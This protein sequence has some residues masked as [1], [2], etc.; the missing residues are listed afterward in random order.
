MSI[1]LTFLSLFLSL[2]RFAYMYL[3]LLPAYSFN[4]KSSC[5]NSTICKLTPAI[6][7]LVENLQENEN[8]NLKCLQDTFK[9]LF[10]AHLNYHSIVN[11]SI[12]SPREVIFFTYFFPLDSF[13]VF[14]FLL[15]CWLRKIEYV[16]AVCNSVICVS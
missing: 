14:L 16:C 6:G 5:T 11:E 3:L 7:S 10:S 12:Y 2:Y 13:F 8:K 4:N 9:T 15:P 1:L